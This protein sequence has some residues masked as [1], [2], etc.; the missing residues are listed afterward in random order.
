MVKYDE[1]GYEIPFWKKAKK[2]VES[3]ETKP[4][5]RSPIMEQKGVEST[6]TQIEETRELSRAEEKLNMAKTVGKD[7]EPYHSE[8][9]TYEEET[10]KKDKEPTEEEWEEVRR[11]S[12]TFFAAT[13]FA[14]IGVYFIFSKK[15]WLV[16]IAIISVILCFA[17]KAK[18]LKRLMDY[19]EELDDR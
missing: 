17:I 12:L 15:M 11:V 6:P 1:N 7:L 19:F 13:A 4:T 5:K 2:K 8:E 9:D 14:S 16:Y 18:I 10:T 3:I